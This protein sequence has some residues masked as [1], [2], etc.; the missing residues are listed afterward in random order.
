[1]RELFI[2]GAILLCTFGT[3]GM[4]DGAYLHLHKYKLYARPE[5]YVE[6][7]THT[8]RALLFPP[9]VYLLLYRTSNSALWVAV[10]L[11]AADL[12]V[13][14]WDVL[15]E[16]ASRKGLGG[17]SSLEYLVHVLAVTLNAAATAVLLVARF[18]S[19]VSPPEG[20]RWV[21]L[22]LIAGGGLTAAQ[23]LWLLQPRY[24]AQTP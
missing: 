7:V 9:L 1:V 23:H 12:G 2:A 6:H 3:I 13:T 16:R 4:I 24:R 19:D 8:L 11:V 20:V 17:L 15:I 5:S 22:A 21:A 14:V 10:A 18:S